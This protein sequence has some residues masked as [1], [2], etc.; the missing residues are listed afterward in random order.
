MAVT[1]PGARGY[2]Q[3]VRSGGVLA[4][5]WIDLLLLHNESAGDTCND[6]DDQLLWPA[7]QLER[8]CALPLVADT[9]TMFELVVCVPCASAVQLS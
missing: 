5:T 6:D 9:H 3:L 7:G 8:S 2:R 4:D 1:G